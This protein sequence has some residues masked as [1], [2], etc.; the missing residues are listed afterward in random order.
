VCFFRSK[1]AVAVVNGTAALHIALLLAGV[2]PGDEVLIP[3]LSFVATANA[4]SHCGAIPHFVDSHIGTLGLDPDALTYYLKD[5]VEVTSQ[6]VRNLQTGRRIA[7]IVPMHTYGHP[8]EMA[9]LL[10]LAN[11]Y[12][13]PV[14]EDAAESLGSIYQG[15]H[16]GTLG[17]LGVLSFNGNKVITTGGGGAILTNDAELARHAK[18]LT[19][20]AKQ[21]HRWEFFHDQ[22]AWNYRLP[23][24]NAAL[25]C[26]QMEQ[27]PVFLQRKRLL[28]EK[29]QAVFR[30]VE[31][32]AFVGEPKNA[33]SNYWLN[34]L[35][36]KQPSFEMRDRFLTVANDAGYQCRPSWTL[37]HKLPMY[38]DCP[39]ASLPVAEQLEASLIN[40]PSSAKLAGDQT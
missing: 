21:P 7:A 25:G 36:L 22:V 31:G 30:E 15:Q 33:H 10:D 35:W 37:L 6:G 12:G 23:N 11:R 17:L 8:V 2:K 5:T 9:S 18:H 3:T 4:V 38:V 27:L 1:Y 16:T 39:S 28:A 19:T 13:L 29:Y 26:A 40:V 14:V 20:T 34:T 24:L 32:I